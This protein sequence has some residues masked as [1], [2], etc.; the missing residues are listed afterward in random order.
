MTVIDQHTNQLWSDSLFFWRGYIY[1]CHFSISNSVWC[2]CLHARG[3]PIILCSSPRQYLLEFS[4][5]FINVCMTCI[6]SLADV[7]SFSI[8]RIYYVTFPPIYSILPFM[9]CT[10]IFIM[11]TAVFDSVTNINKHDYI[12]RNFCNCAFVIIG[13]QRYSLCNFDELHLWLIW[14]LR[15]LLPSLLNYEENV[16]YI[17]ESASGPW[18][19]K[20]RDLREACTLHSVQPSPSFFSTLRK[21]CDF[22]CFP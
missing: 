22:L 7:A 5:Y 4:L 3:E 17:E 6:D 18:M 10:S 14:F 21:I 12:M 8:S 2:A 15:D 1:Y 20:Q 13:I 19:R 9:R 11:S 16:S